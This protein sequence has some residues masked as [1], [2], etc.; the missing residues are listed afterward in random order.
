[1]KNHIRSAFYLLILLIILLTAGCASRGKASLPQEP[2]WFSELTESEDADRYLIKISSAGSHREEALQSAIDQLYDRIT[3]LSESL[4]GK[5]GSDVSLM[6]AEIRKIIEGN[7]SWLAGYLSV[8]NQEWIETDSGAYYFGAFYLNK[9][10]EDSLF[11]MMI[12]RLYGGDEQLKDMLEKA[13]RFE[14]EGNL[15]QSAEELIRAAVY[16]QSLTGLMKDEISR[17]F[18][19]KALSLLQRI[20]VETLRIP[21]GV[22]SNLRIDIPFQLFCSTEGKGLESVEFLVNYQGKKRDGTRGDFVRRVVSNANGLLEFY[23]PFIP[24]TGKSAV[25][26]VPGSRDFHAGLISLENDGLDVSGIKDWVA[27][28]TNSYDLDV[29]SGARS[30]PMGIVLLHTDI[31]GSALRQED[32]AFSLL[33]SLAQNG[34]NISILPLDP[35]ELSSLSEAEF[36]RDLRAQYKGKYTRV[37]FGVVGIEDFETR[38]DSFR[39]NTAGYL[40]VVDVESSEILFSMNTDKS[41]ESRSNTLAVSTSFRELG[42]AFAEE[43]IQT[44]E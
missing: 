42:K 6:K 34:F 44:L 43:I 32:S 35:K 21:D 2:A 16:V 27:K 36:L 24:F 1:M 38:N 20:D 10:A 22:M 9:N 19:D 18:L 7:D 5:S 3:S 4:S 33:D 30:V 13:A 14:E 31:T 8:I 11:E 39:V 29:S 17:Q 25:K 15:Y 26:F 40:K 41:V 28:K 23:H 12:D 37:I